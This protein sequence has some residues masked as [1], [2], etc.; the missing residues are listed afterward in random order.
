MVCLHYCERIAQSP[1][2]FPT[3]NRSEQ[4]QLAELPLK[5]V[6]PCLTYVLGLVLGGVA[7]IPRRA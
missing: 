3:E 7:S 4:G 5:I 2:R 6:V 1:P